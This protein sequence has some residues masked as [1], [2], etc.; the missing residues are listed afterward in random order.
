MRHDTSSSTSPLNDHWRPLARTYHKFGPKSLGLSAGKLLNIHGSWY[1]PNHSDR[2]LRPG[3]MSS[4]LFPRSAVCPV[5]EKLV[6][7]RKKV[8]PCAIAFFRHCPPRN[9]SDLG[10]QGPSYY[11]AYLAETVDSHSIFF[12]CTQV[13]DTVESRGKRSAPVMPFPWQSQ[14]CCDLDHCTAGHCS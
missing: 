2:V 8:A 12:D 13:N 6:A 5:V 7:T 1:C 4:G 11:S 9:R 10:C 3:S 14:G